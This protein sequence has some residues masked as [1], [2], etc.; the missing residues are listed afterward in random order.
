MAHRQIRWAVTTTTNR[1]QLA[2]A[3]RCSS[4]QG[5]HHGRH[6]GREEEVFST[7]YNK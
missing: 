3:W 7:A 5:R 4:E 2:Y 6:Q 1:S